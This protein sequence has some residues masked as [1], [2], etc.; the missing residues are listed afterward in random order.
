[1]ADRLTSTHFEVFSN[2]FA[3]AQKLSPGV[4]FE[5]RNAKSDRK[6]DRRK[7]VE[8]KVVAKKN[9]PFIDGDDTVT[10]LLLG[11]E[12]LLTMDLKADGMYLVATGPDGD[13]ARNSKVKSLRSIAV[14]D[15][16][17]KSVPAAGAAAGKEQNFDDTDDGLG[18]NSTV[19]S[20]EARAGFLIMLDR[21]G[22]GS[23]PVKKSAALWV[24]LERTLG[25]IWVT[26][27]AAYFADEGESG[28]QGKSGKA[29]GAA[30]KLTAKKI[31]DAWPFPGK[32]GAK[33]GRKPKVARTEGEAPAAKTTGAKRG[34]KPRV[35]SAE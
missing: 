21:A 2:Y 30:K 35:A 9:V 25:K 1:M 17:P 29:N 10:A 16:K 12:D 33:R 8:Y 15:G 14:A 19:R 3:D 26:A 34:R 5:L 22:C 27:M 28:K 6:I 32:T 13:I 24:A 7:I 18:F 23:L 20:D 4:S 31:A 11:I